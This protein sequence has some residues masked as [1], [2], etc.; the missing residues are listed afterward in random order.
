MAVTLYTGTPGSGKSFNAAKRMWSQLRLKRDVIS[1]VNI[2]LNLISNNGKKKLG[3]FTYIPIQELTPEFLYAYYSIYHTK[4]KEH[5]TL[6]VIDECQTIFDTMGYAQK[7]RSEWQTFFAKHRHMGYEVMLLTQHDKLIDKKIRCQL[8]YEMVH[9]KINNYGFMWMFPFKVFAQISYWYGSKMRMSG[10]FILFRKKYAQIY[11]SYMIFDSL[12]EEKGMTEE[13]ALEIL[14]NYPASNYP[15][16]SPSPKQSA[17]NRFDI[18]FSDHLADGGAGDIIQPI[19]GTPLA[20]G[21][22]R[23]PAVGEGSEGDVLQDVPC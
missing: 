12:L 15:L 6:L 14:N 1:T 10:G 7:G 22:G 16:S 3:R 13:I 21:W 17:K 5:S 2:D 20:R 23:G 9:R 4:G 8:E 19:P 11:D 18:N